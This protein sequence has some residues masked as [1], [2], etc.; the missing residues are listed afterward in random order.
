MKLAPTDRSGI[1]NLLQENKKGLVELNL[2][3]IFI[4]FTGIP[5]KQKP[6]LGLLPC[7]GKTGKR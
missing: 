4:S 1:L 7:R 2:L 5:D 6:V 3:N